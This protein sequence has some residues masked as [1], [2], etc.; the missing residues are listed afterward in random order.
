MQRRYHSC[1]G[2]RGGE[3]AEEKECGCDLASP[4]CFTEGELNGMAA[5]AGFADR[6]TFYHR[7]SDEVTLPE[8]ADL[9]V[10]DAKQIALLSHVALSEEA[11]PRTELAEMLW[12][13]GDHSRSRHNLR[14]C[15]L[16]LRCRCPAGPDRDDRKPGGHRL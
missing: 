6:I 15:L 13:G 12:P 4:R 2:E 10:H 11:V 16:A 8:R 14:Q 9:I 1:R 3:R 5:E 7:T